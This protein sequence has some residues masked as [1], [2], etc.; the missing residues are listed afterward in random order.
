MEDL[1]ENLLG[2]EIKCECGTKHYIPIKRVVISKGALNQFKDIL[3]ELDFKNHFHIIADKNTYKVAG[4]RIEKL[5]EE[6]SFKYTITVF[7]DDELV[8]SESNVD[9]IRRE[10]GSQVSLIIAVG[11]GTINDLSRYAAFQLKIP[12]LIVATAPSMDGYASNVS[13]L[14]VKGFK[15][16]YSAVAPIAIIG[17]IDIIKEAP[18]QMIAAGFGDLIGKY[19]SLSDWKL[20]NIL[21]GEYYCEYVAS[22]VH[23][24]LILCVDNINGLKERSEEAVGNLMN[25]LVLSGLGMLMVGNSRPASGAEH[26]LSHFWEMKFLMQGRKQLLHGQKVG[27]SSV[28]MANL[29]S[30]LKSM[31]IFEIVEK[32]EHIKKQSIDEKKDRIKTVFGS[33]ADEVMKE[34]FAQ[35]LFT[36]NANKFTE[37][38]EEILK[39]ANLV[40]ESKDIKSMLDSIGAFS[41]PEQLMIDQVLLAE[42]MENCMYVRNRYTILRLYDDLG[43][44]I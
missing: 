44:S 3:L 1:Y 43:L 17:D 38:W 23:K 6:Y 26:H 14:I 15:N 29:Y 24:T 36:Q 31:N 2:R 5:L 32:Q 42:G 11:S 35:T 20:S 39:I 13:P 28:L 9:R 21:N 12:Y 40:P 16:T 30:S 41:T 7:N 4:N 10:I 27:V 8:A 22:I 18:E 37:K 34:N 25:G 19:I 33:I